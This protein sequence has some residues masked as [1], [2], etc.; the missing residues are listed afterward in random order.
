M[1]RCHI[2]LTP[3][4]LEDG[5]GHDRRVDHRTQVRQPACIED[6]NLGPF[7]C[8]VS[9]GRNSFAI[10]PDDRDRRLQRGD[11]GRVGVAVE[12]SPRT[13]EAD[14]LETGGG[15]ERDD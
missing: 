13:I 10:G 2:D 11:R 8:S 5:R 15:S 7:G 6:G 12:F 14:A 4:G 9:K 3:A 1:E